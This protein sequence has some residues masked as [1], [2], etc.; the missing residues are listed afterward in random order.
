MKKAVSRKSSKVSNSGRFKRS[1]MKKSLI[2]SQKN[3]NKN[4]SV[5][6]GKVENSPIGHSIVTLRGT[7]KDW[8]GKNSDNIL[9]EQQEYSKKILAQQQLGSEELISY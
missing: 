3:N 9:M 2:I 1:N 5:S 8:S 6:V 4:D 7:T